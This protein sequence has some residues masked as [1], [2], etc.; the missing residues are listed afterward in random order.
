[1]IGATVMG[2]ST[3]TMVGFHEISGLRTGKEKL[4]FDFIM[5][6]PTRAIA[7]WPL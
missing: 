5:S 3:N 1:M 7:D 4:S 2:W 6:I